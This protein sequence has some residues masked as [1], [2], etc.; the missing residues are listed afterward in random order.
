MDVKP[1]V[2]IIV[3]VYNAEQFLP[4]CLDSL[5]NQTYQEIEIICVNDG[6]QDASLDILNNYARQDLRIK[7]IDKENEGVSR[8][9]SEALDFVRGT[10]IMFVDADDWIE[11][12]TCETVVNKAIETSADVI[13]WPYMR[14]HNSESMPKNIFDKDVEFDENDVKK[15][16]HRRMIGM[17]GDELAHPENADALC[18]VW[19]KLY[20][21]DIIKNNKLEFIDLSEIGTYED[22]MFNLYYFEHVKKAIYLNKHMYHYRRTNSDSVTSA[23]KEDLYIRWQRLFELMHNYIVCNDLSQEYEDALNNRIALSLLGLG[24][25]IFSSSLTSGEK[26]KLLKYIISQEIYQKVYKNLEF[27]YFP[28]QWKLFYGCARYRFSIGVYVL[29]WV[30]CKCRA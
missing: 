30:I 21:A 23:Y 15:K 28:V 10:Y 20:K 19:G 6:S 2:S 16:I 7:V 18:T 29:L 11:A 4:K 25:N 1:L 26:I 13:I 12:Q 22:G 24:L 3:P 5:I 14:V 8:A 27:K 17:V 9:R